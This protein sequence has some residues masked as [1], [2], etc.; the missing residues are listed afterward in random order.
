MTPK[1]ESGPTPITLPPTTWHSKERWVIV[2]IVTFSGMC[3]IGVIPGLQDISS[4]DAGSWYGIPNIDISWLSVV[5]TF[6]GIAFGVS[7]GRNIALAGH[8][9][10]VLAGKHRFGRPSLLQKGIRFFIALPLVLLGISLLVQAIMKEILLDVV[11]VAIKGSIGD[12]SIFVIVGTVGGIAIT[13]PWE[14]YFRARADR[15]HSNE[16]LTKWGKR[17]EYAQGLA[18]SVADLPFK[19]VQTATEATRAVASQAASATRSVAGASLNMAGRMPGEVA[20]TAHQITSEIPLPFR[21]PT[22]PPNA[23][24]QAPYHPSAPSPPAGAEQVAPVP[25]VERYCPACGAG[26]A[27]AYAFCQRC[28][29]ALPT[30]S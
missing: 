3:L 27:R 5:F 22:P 1:I 13:I 4:G 19:V 20:R 21:R 2:L 30:S 14:M 25:N 15:F 18:H 7:A 17:L 16:C 26:N 6:L 23:P 10:A 24:S 12:W 8:D 9:R 29:R 11:S 28:G